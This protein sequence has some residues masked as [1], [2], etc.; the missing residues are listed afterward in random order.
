[1]ARDRPTR[2]RHRLRRRRWGRIIFAATL[3]IILVAGLLLLGG[4]ILIRHYDNAIARA[5]LLA[6]NA[7]ADAGHRAVT[8]PLNYLLI[9]SDYRK[10]SPDAGQRSDTIIIA[11]V[12]KALDHVYLISVPRDLLV[13]MRPV[14]ELEFGGA[15]T[16]INAAFEYGHGGD[17]GTQILSQTLSDLAGIR[18]DGAAVVS[19]TGLVRAVDM[20]GGVKLCIDTRTVSVHTG[21]AFE[22]GCR[23]MQSKEVLDY[24]RQRNFPDGDFARQRHQ[25]QFLKAFLDQ[26][27]SKGV[28]ANPL[29]MDALVRAVG[30]AVT[31]DTGGVSVPDLVFALRDVRPSSITGI[32]IPSYLDNIDSVSYVIPTAEADSLFTAIR[33][34]ALDA[35]VTAHTN[36][37]NTI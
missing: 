11:H 4:A 35:W 32:K 18:F 17:G 10:W 6:P 5:T 12:P 25:Q 36:W 16:K 30:S 33:D 37:V 20:L 15:R 9:G 1:M 14:P 31:V 27:T 8:G 7:R 29:K 26:M 23:L 28:L 24:L 3:V 22:P 13:E 19:F 2:P 34:D 21:A